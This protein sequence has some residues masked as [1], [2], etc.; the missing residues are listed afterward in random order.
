M[1]ESHV[2]GHSTRRVQAVQVSVHL[3]GYLGRD[4]WG[5]NAQPGPIPSHICCAVTEG[6]IQAFRGLPLPTSR[7][8]LSPCKNSRTRACSIHVGRSAQV[9]TRAG[10]GGTA[11]GDCGA[12]AEA[13]T[14]TGLHADRCTSGPG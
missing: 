3:I 7:G 11:T 6:S 13:A 2:I 10:P 14:R 9:P 1:K 4:R 8:T 12:P 5:C